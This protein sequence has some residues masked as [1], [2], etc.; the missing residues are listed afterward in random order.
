MPDSLRNPMARRGSSNPSKTDPNNTVVATNR[1]ARRDFEILDTWEAGIV[2]QGSE[3]K[4]LRESKVTLS[5]AYARLVAG[6]LWLIGLHVSPYSHA[7]SQGGHVVDRDRKMLVHLHEIDEMR[8]RLDQERL[9]LIPL[10]MYF[11]AGRCKVEV[12]L[13]RGRKEFDKRQVIAEREADR[14]ARRAMVRHGKGT[15]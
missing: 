11:K 1:Q 13:G 5:D 12:G 3:V 15:D 7:A 4:S 14:E 9:T 10:S 6:E 2:L 8:A